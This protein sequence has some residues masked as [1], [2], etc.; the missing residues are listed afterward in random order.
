MSL[1]LR[2]LI[3]G[4]AA[5]AWGAAGF[6]VE[7]GGFEVGGVRVV[8]LGDGGG[9]DRWSLA[10]EGQA[11]VPDVDGIATVT[12]EPTE[13]APTDH[14]NGITGFDHVVVRSPDLDRTTQ[15]FD[16]LGL[17]CRRIREVPGSDGAQQR[18]FLLG[19]AV[20]ELVGPAVPTGDEP[21]TI[22]GY[23]LVA[24]DLD[25]TARHLGDRLGPVRDAVQRGRRIATLRTRELGISIPVAVMSPRSR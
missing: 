25:A 20:L 7:G 9:H 2:A 24:H 1:T 22:W 18:F 8:C 5:E 17:E 11:T 23:A 16:R 13:P 15:A 3:T 19:T 12:R 6:S 4:D 14:P 10:A 21:A